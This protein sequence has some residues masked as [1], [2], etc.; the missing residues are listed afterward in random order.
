[1]ASEDR[2]KQGIIT[3]LAKRAAN[4][5][6][7]P[8]CDAITSGPAADPSGSVNVGE[9]AHIYGANPGS[10]RFDPQMTPADRGAI[11]NAIWLCATCHKKVDDDA[12]RYPA[13]L[14]FEWQRAHENKIAQE[15]GKAAAIIRA[16]Y[17]KRHLEEFGRLSYLAERIVLEKGD[18]WE[19]H[20]AAEVIR[21]EIAPILRRWRALQEGLYS[22]PLMRL[23]G[24]E[25]FSWIGSKMGEV[26]AISSAFG[27]LVNSEFSRA[28]GDPGVP[29]NDQEIVETCRLTREMCQSALQWEEDVRFVNVDDEFADVMQLLVG[30]A[31]AIMDEVVKLQAFFSETLTG[32]IASGT[33]TLAL[34]LNLP[35]GWSE[36][37][38]R[39]LAKAAQSLS[40]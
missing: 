17:E 15:V 26:V 29:G 6:S 37:I 25:G 7:N 10:A 3:T 4:R 23:H 19:Y 31:G 39:A 12:G 24:I 36:A 20:L 5:C 2:F 33:Y 35:D 34:Q 32:S 13:G 22:K 11:T 40:S 18:Y 16:R 9:A 21:F 28:W 1:M 27:K 14:L 38:E 30:R 8:D